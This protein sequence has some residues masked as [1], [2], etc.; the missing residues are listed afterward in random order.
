MKQIKTVALKCE[1]KDYIDFHNLTEFQGGLKI[2]NEDDIQKAKTSILKY[3][4]SFPVFVWKDKNTNYVIDGHCRLLVLKELEAEGYIIPE[5]P[6]VY[7]ECKNKKEAKQ[8]LLRLNSNFGHF[9]K[10]SVLEFAED[11]EINFDEIQLP[12]GIISFTDGTEN[13]TGGAIKNN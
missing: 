7:I 6:V 4:W 3:G 11:L 9:T 13:E 10:E 12:E 5:L 2:R 1:T 8:K